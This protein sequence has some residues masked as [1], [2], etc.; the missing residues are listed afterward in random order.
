M[1]LSEA[2]LAARDPPPLH[3]RGPQSVLT[4]CDPS[5]T[6]AVRSL[7]I[8]SGIGRVLQLEKETVLLRSA[9]PGRPTQGRPAAGLAVGS[10]S[11]ELGEQTGVLGEHPNLPGTPFM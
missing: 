10:L 4:S 7:N 3:H 6:T 8:I 5:P 11:L 2:R 1:T 9:G